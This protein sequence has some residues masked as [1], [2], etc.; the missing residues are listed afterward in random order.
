VSK[1][2][3]RT[4]CFDEAIGPRRDARP[5]GKIAT[6]EPKRKKGMPTRGD[7]FGKKSGGT[8]EKRV[9]EVYGKKSRTNKWKGQNSQLKM[10]HPEGTDVHRGNLEIHGE[11]GRKNYPGWKK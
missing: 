7:T 2:V 6:A 3:V 11:H 8:R 10:L 5:G 4:E 1:R 9:S